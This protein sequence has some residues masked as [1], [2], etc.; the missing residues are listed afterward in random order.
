MLV[1]FPLKSFS[2]NLLNVLH[3]INIRGY[4][5]IVAHPERY[6]F[7]LDDPLAINE[8]L[9]YQV[10]FQINAG[11]II[12]INGKQSKKFAIELIKQGLVSFIASD[13]HSPNWRPIQLRKVIDTLKGNMELYE[14]NK[15]FVDNVE[16]LLNN[17]KINNVIRKFAYDKQ[18]F[19]R[20]LKKAIGL[21]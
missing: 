12:G 6:Q 10:F 17:N 15:M 7:I 14:L 13:G 18:S 5:P 11:S 2:R 8:L 1:E 20:V 9:Q 4:I 3:E 16:K 19:L 21:K